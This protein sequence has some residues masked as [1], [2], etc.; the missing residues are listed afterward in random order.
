MNGDE[1]SGDRS[2]SMVSAVNSLPSG[3][4]ATVGGSWPKPR[5]GGGGGGG[6]VPGP[7]VR[8]SACP[9][10]CRPL[11]AEPGELA[12]IRDILSASAHQVKPHG[13]PHRAPFAHQRPVLHQAPGQ[14]PTPTSAHLRI[15]ASRSPHPPGS[16]V[17]RLPSQT[18]HVEHHR[19]LS[20]RR[21]P[22]EQPDPVSTP[23]IAD[24]PMRRPKV[25]ATWSPSPTG[26]ADATTALPN[27]RLERPR[28][29]AKGARRSS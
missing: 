9:T 24:A 14:G 11:D 19:F 29:L 22:S 8:G 16:W 21:H 5:G 12:V 17:P 27:V 13:V 7:A 3:G 28:S 1:S 15:A 26:R 23:D 18:F 2:W 4:D 6:T 20:E 10:T 25:A